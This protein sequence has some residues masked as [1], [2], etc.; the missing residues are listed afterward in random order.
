MINKNK[1]KI[2]QRDILYYNKNHGVIPEGY[3]LHHLY[4]NENCYDEDS[5]IIITQEEHEQIHGHNIPCST[6]NYNYYE[7]KLVSNRLSNKKWRDNNV[8]R[9]KDKDRKKDKELSDI[10]KHFNITQT[11]WRSCDKDTKKF[12]RELYREINNK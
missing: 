2:R 1:D 10:C 5:F 11:I 9:C 12:M 3:T 8:E 4:Y 6:G 7:R